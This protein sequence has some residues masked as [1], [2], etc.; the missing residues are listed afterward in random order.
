MEDK[1]DKII[2]VTF[3]SIY[4]S[5]LSKT[6]KMEMY[7]LYLKKGCRYVKNPED[8]QELS[9]VYQKYNYGEKISMFKLP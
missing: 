1:L 4:N 7:E 8:F 6:G 5:N 3:P 9:K 2:Q